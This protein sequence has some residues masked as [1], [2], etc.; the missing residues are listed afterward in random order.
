[1]SKRFERMAQKSIISEKLIMDFLTFKYGLQFH[2]VPQTE[3]QSMSI[4]GLHVPDILCV[5]KPNV[6]FEVKEDILSKKN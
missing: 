3:Q 1:M 4:N 5:E 6:A 2:L